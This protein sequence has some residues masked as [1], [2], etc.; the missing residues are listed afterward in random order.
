MLANPVNA[1]RLPKRSS[2]L[3]LEQVECEILKCS[4]SFVRSMF[5]PQGGTK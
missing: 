4:F 3:N 5:T 1:N 2:V